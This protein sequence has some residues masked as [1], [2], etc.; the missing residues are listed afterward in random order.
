MKNWKKFVD[1][2]ID[3]AKHET[4][5]VDMTFEAKYGDDKDNL[6][7]ILVKAKKKYIGHYRKKD[8]LSSPYLDEEILAA[9]FQSL[10]DRFRTHKILY[11]GRQWGHKK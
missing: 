3:R 4:N 11:W 8:Y 6:V 9:L 1:K 7:I 2:A 5:S 10:K